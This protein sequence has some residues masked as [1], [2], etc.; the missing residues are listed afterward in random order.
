M[1]AAEWS[2]ARGEVTPASGY[3]RSE[4][5]TA[6]TKGRRQGGPTGD[7]IAFAIL[8]RITKAAKTRR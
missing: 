3:I 5:Q 7:K 4:Q 8:E 2:T 6:T 1:D